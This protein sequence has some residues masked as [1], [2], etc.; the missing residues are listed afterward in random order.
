M[1][2]KKRHSLN[3]YFILFLII[4][5]T[6]FFSLSLV[7]WKVLAKRVKNNVADSYSQNLHFYEEQITRQMEQ[8]EKYVYALFQNP[9]YRNLEQKKGSSKYEYAKTNIA[10][11]LSE[12]DVMNSGITDA[13][14]IYIRSSDEVIG[15][16]DVNEISFLE[17]RSLLL[18]AKECES[19]EWHRQLIDGTVYLLRT[20]SYR[21]TIVSV[22][23]KEKKIVEEW[24]RVFDEE[25]GLIICEADSNSA[26]KGY[27]SVSRDFCG[28][29]MQM[30][31]QIP[32]KKFSVILYTDGRLY[33][34]ALFL[35]ILLLSGSMIFF[36][37]M[38]L[39]PVLEMEQTIQQIGNS[40]TEQ[41]MP[42]NQ[43]GLELYSLALNFNQMMDRIKKLKIQTYE[44]KLAGEKSKLLNL[45]LQINPHLLLNSLNTIYGLAELHDFPAIQQFSMNLVKYFR[46]SLRDINRLVTLKEEVEFTQSYVKVQQVRY[47]NRFY[48]FYDVDE[49]LFPL[50]IPPLL[51]QNF[52][53]NSTKYALCDHEVEVVVTAR[54]SENCLRLSIRDDG[55]GIDQEI[56]AGIRENQPLKM[57]GVSHL[58]IWNCR[59]RMRLYY[60]EKAKFSIISEPGEGTIVWMEIPVSEEE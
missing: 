20:F 45:Q 23:V 12:S 56:L 21:N 50:Q 41:R 37:R 59:N 2:Q 38:L 29:N 46:Y 43:S 19:Q 31:I 34:L 4:I 60:G 44:L 57:N 18:N 8:A 11:S 32:E 24:N 47:P 48:V 39:K 13:L 30:R 25:I 1:M 14:N 54:L 3:W 33:I 55:R 58:G 53:E 27:F 52:V 9:L 17:N 5:L 49:K 16:R 26:E 42:E 7:W 35:C 40:E 28:K 22:Y 15:Y 36:H 10:R 6:V 51:I